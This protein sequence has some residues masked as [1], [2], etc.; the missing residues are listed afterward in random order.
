MPGK[1][2]HA[3]SAKIREELASANERL[4]S[5]SVTESCMVAAA[6]AQRDDVR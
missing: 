3:E 5:T 6:T 1:K 2:A 4:S